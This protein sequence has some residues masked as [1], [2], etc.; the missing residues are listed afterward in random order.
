MRA[1]AAQVSF[2]AALQRLDVEP[3]AF[4][5]AAAMASLAAR[6][7]RKM[8]SE[9]LVALENTSTTR[10]LRSTA[11]MIEPAQSAPGGTSRGA[12]QQRTPRLSSVLTTASAIALSE[13]G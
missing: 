6:T 4:G 10:R 9:V 12:T 13:W 3:D 2:D 1:H 11:S 5:H 8:C 7:S